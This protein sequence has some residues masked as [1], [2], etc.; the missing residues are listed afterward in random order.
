VETL[1]KYFDILTMK[2]QLYVWGC[3]AVAGLGWYG[4]VNNKAIAHA[5]SSTPKVAVQTAS[6]PFNQITQ[7]VN[8]S[9]YLANNSTIA[10]PDDYRE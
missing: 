6:V 7:L 2:N 9:Q 4:V 10:I 8:Q 1:T 3:L 5:T